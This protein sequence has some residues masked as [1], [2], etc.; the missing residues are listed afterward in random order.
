MTVDPSLSAG[1]GNLGFR[2]NGL[3]VANQVIVFGTGGG[4]FVYNGTPGVGNL[5]A[6]I[7]PANG[8]DQ[9]GNAYYGPGFVAYAG[10]GANDLV[11]FMKAGVLRLSTNSLINTGQAASIASDV[12]GQN[13]VLQ[14]GST[15]ID[16]T[17]IQQTLTQIIMQSQGISSDPL[18]NI[19]GNL[20][21]QGVLELPNQSTPL[22]NAGQAWVYATSGHGKYVAPNGVGFN[23]GRNTQ[24]SSAPLNLTTSFQNIPGIGVNIENGITYHYRAQVL[25]NNPGTVGQGAIGVQVAAGPTVGTGRFT[26]REIASNGTVW[27]DYA[28]ITSALNSANA[29]GANTN[30]RVWDI[31]AIFTCTGSGFFTFQMKQ[32]ATAACN[33]VQNGTYGELFPIS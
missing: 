4:I 25:I 18:V 10:Q 8:T 27:E 26:A 14:S 19:I 11:A 15:G 20:I 17:A 24:P 5:I 33:T 32:L 16:G 23:T 12:T 31:D 2:N 28:A 22:G 7:A 9:F 13:L 1:F 29:P 3:V 21:V 6:S 30:N